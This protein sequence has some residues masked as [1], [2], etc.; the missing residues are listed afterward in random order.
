MDTNEIKI[1]P[2]TEADAA[3]ILNIYAPYITDTAITFEYD[4]PTLEEFTG[5]IRHT[6]E[7]YPYLVAVRDSEII[8]YAYAGA[9][10][11]RAAYDWS[12]E[13][14]IY[15]KK[16]CSHSGVGKLLYQ[17]LE[18][19]L[20]AQNIINLYACIGYPEEDDEYLTKNSKQF[21]EHLGYRFEF[22]PVACSDH[23]IVVCCYQTESA[24]DK[25][26]CNN[27]DYKPCLQ[28]SKRDHADHSRTYKQFICQR[29]HKL[30]EIGYKISGPG[31]LSV[32]HICKTCHAE[33]NQ[34]DP[35]VCSSAH[36][37]QHEKYKKRNHDYS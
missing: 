35:F 22:S 31:D 20:K 11:G 12:A 18:T 32:Q 28:F 15:V 19:A 24:D 14:T 2:A 8:G 13:T 23:N 27:Y 17:A 7:K 1:R 3:E 29:I 30:S 33:N 5:R 6:L 10:Y 26:S 21:H 36:A 16:G 37:C 25:F 34:C 4:V 9:F